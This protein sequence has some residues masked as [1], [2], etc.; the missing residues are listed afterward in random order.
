MFSQYVEDLP[1]YF[2]NIQNKID[3]IYV[4]DQNVKLPTTNQTLNF[5]VDTTHLKTYVQTS[6]YS[7]SLLILSFIVYSSLISFVIKLKTV[8]FHSFNFSSLNL[9]RSVKSKKEISVMKFVASVSSNA[10]KEVMLSCKPGMFEYQLESIFLF[11]TSFC[12]YTLPINS[13]SH[14]KHTLNTHTHTHTSN[15]LIKKLCVDLI[16]VFCLFDVE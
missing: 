6:T 3:T 8:L 16:L 15:Q 4:L 13:N 14:T 10:H 9:A 7:L 2:Q 12:G 11:N 5:T 1:T